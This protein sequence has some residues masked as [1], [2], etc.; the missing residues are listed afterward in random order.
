MRGLLCFLFIF[1]AVS[2]LRTAVPRRIALKRAA[3]FLLVPQVV[4]AEDG[5][6]TSSYKRT[7]GSENAAT[8]AAFT[9][10]ALE[11]NDR[12]RKSGVKVDTDE[13][14]NKRLSDALS[15]YSYDSASGASKQQKKANSGSG[16]RR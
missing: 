6:Q 3:S 9:A 8:T 11:T 7:P 4:G 15:S 12:L 14:A 16:G 13:E 2:S 1:R 10:Q 5:T